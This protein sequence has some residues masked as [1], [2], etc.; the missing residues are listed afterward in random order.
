MT[1]PTA[2]R[3]PAV[4]HESGLRRLA[5]W[6]SFR[7][8][9]L[10][11]EF[12]AYLADATKPPR[13]NAVD[14]AGQYQ[15]SVVVYA[16]A[17]HG[18][19]DAI[20]SDSHYVTSTTGA[21]PSP[22]PRRSRAAAASL[23]TTPA[24]RESSLSPLYYSSSEDHRFSSGKQ[25]FYERGGRLGQKKIAVKKVHQPFPRKGVRCED[26]AKVRQLK[27]DFACRFMRAGASLGL[28]RRL[29][30]SGNFT[31]TKTG[32]FLRETHPE[33]VRELAI[34]LNAE[35]RE[36][37]YA[38]AEKSL[39]TGKSGFFEALGS[40][41]SSDWRKRHDSLRDDRALTELR[42]PTL[43]AFVGDFRL[44][45]TETVCDLLG[46][47]GELLRDVG[48][49]WPG[50]SLVLLEAPEAL[51]RA[52]DYLAARV[53]RN[54]FAVLPGSLLSSKLPTA[55]H[56]CDVFVLH[57]V[58]ADSPDDQAVK[59]LQNV[60]HAARKRGAKLLLVDPLLDRGVYGFDT[61]KKLADVHQLATAPPG[62]K[63]RDFAQLTA[64]LRRAHLNASS[65]DRLA[66]KPSRSPASLLLLPLLM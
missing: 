27:A 21:G 42:Q 34:S 30:S 47:R 55:L 61:S 11:H 63:I 19:F 58:L 28:L 22:P 32:D 12:F 66:L 37:W 65:I 60:K 49:H 40:V 4:P 1:S 59:I 2:V 43:A 17:Y 29:R 52:V 38:A 56:A 26:V 7:F 15:T 18:M 62:A 41:S 16:L 44:R 24:G 48:E 5:R 13:A 33:S 8:S 57:A 64:L 50:T 14:L 6:P 45:G 46:G 53:G 51:P 36:A 9:L 23:V 3:P 31:T 35:T 10:A 54:R 20:P 25:H 39:L